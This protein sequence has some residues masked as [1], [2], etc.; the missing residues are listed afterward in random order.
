MQIY[1]FKHLLSPL[2]DFTF[3]L[4]TAAS[5]KRIRQWP[6]LL[7]EENQLKP[8]NIIVQRNTQFTEKFISNMN[9]CISKIIGASRI[10]SL[11]SCFATALLG[12]TFSACTVL[13]PPRI[14]RPVPLEP[15]I[16]ERVAP[17]SDGDLL[18]TYVLQ[19]RKL[20]ADDFMVE[21]NRVRTEFSNSSSEFN[22]VKLAVMLALS[23]SAASATASAT[24]GNGGGEDT[25][26]IAL[27]DPL[28]FSA[29]A[30]G[31]AVKPELRA[32]AYIL[33]GMANERKRLRELAK[34]A[35]TKI[36]VIKRDESSIVESKQLKVRIEDL[37]RQLAA[38]KSIEKSVGARGESASK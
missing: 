13:D 34:I 18:M 33:Q 10:K 15:R 20:S 4:L 37:E 11:A 22:R 36:T 32:L 1:K 38:L 24:N 35:Q 14:E 27:L 31:S 16:I 28:V 30:S 3:I 26:L 25:E 7:F 12:V 2:F 5:T 8:C 17:P 6:I 21:Q 19:V 29:A 23:P 9:A